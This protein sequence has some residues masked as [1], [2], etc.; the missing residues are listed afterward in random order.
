MTCRS[1]ADFILDYLSGDL[2]AD[3][4]GEFERHVERCPA[5][6]RYIAVYRTAVDL[7]RAAFDDEDASAED[8]GVP[9]ELI[10]AILASRRST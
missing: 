7:G 5:C 3:V 4:L 1:V 2:A 9:R 8:A 6:E 10:D